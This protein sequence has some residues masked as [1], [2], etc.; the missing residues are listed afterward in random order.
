MKSEI[1]TIR[2]ISHPGLLPIFDE[3][4]DEYWY[5]T[6]FF[7]GGTLA[8]KPDL[9]QNRVL[10]SLRALRPVVEAVAELHQVGRVHRDIKPA[11]VF[12]D[13]ADRLVLGDCGLAFKRETADRMTA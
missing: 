2:A 3:N 13:Q 4:I 9:Y 10:D 6:K 5:V 12:I 7:S 11:N 1:E 8:S